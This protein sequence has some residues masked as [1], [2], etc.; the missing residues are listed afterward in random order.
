MIT[1]H[2]I[3]IQSGCSFIAK[4]GTIDIALDGTQGNLTVRDAG[5]FDAKYATL[6]IR[7]DI[8]VD[9]SATFINDEGKT[10]L[11]D[12]VSSKGDGVQSITGSLTFNELI[13]TT[14]TGI[15]FQ[16]GSTQTIL[17]KIYVRGTLGEYIH[18][19]SSEND[20]DLDTNDQWIL[21]LPL[22]STPGYTE[23][24]RYISV[25][26]SNNLRYDPNDDLGTRIEAHYA[27]DEGVNRGWFCDPHI[28]N[29]TG[30]TDSAWDVASNW[31]E[32]RTPQVMTIDGED[33]LDSVIIHNASNQPVLTADAH[34]DGRVLG[35]TID[36]GAT[37]DLG[38]YSF[39]VEGP[40]NNSGTIRLT[41]VSSQTI[42]F[43]QGNDI[44]SGTFRY[45]GSGVGEALTIKDFG[46]VDYYNLVV[47][48]QEDDVFSLEGASNVVKGNLSVTIPGALGEFQATGPTI[49][50]GN[51]TINDGTYTASSSTSVPGVWVNGILTG[52]NMTISGGASYA[53]TGSTVL[54]G[55]LT[56]NS[57]AYS[58]AQTTIKGDLSLSSGTYTASGATT[59]GYYAYNELFGGN[60]AMTNSSTYTSGGTTTINGSFIL[61]SGIYDSA[62]FATTVVRTMRI[63]GGEY[64]A[65]NVSDVTHTF[66]NLDVSGGTF[67]GRKATIDIN[68]DL[69]LGAGDFYMPEGDIW[70][71]G[72]WTTNSVGD[73]FQIPGA[74]NTVYFDTTNT[75]LVDGAILNKVAFYDLVIQDGGTL[76]LLNPLQ[77]TNKLE[78]KGGSTLDLGFFNLT[79]GE[80]DENG[81][82][83]PGTEGTFIN[84]KSLLILEGNEVLA[85]FTNDAANEG[86]VLYNSTDEVEFSDLAAGLH[87]YNLQ[88]DSAATFNLTGTLDVDGS[89]DIMNGTLKTNN[90][91]IEL[92]GNWN[93]DGTVEIGES[94][95]YLDGASDLYPQYITSGGTGAGKQFYN[96]EH[97]V[98]ADA[99]LDGT[100]KIDDPIMVLNNFTN[101]AGT[102]DVNDEDM[103]VIGATVIEGGEL[104]TGEGTL[105]L[106]TVVV[107]ESGEVI[108]ESL[109]PNDKI[110]KTSWEN[111]A[112]TVTYAATSTVDSKALLSDVYTY[113]TLAIDSVDLS[114]YTL[115]GNLTISGDLRL[116]G[117]KLDA[118]E[119]PLTG[120]NVYNI[121]LAGDWVSTGGVFVPRTSTVTL[122]G[123]GQ[124]ILGDN[125]FYNLVKDRSLATAPDTLTLESGKTLTIADEG[126]LTLKGG[127]NLADRLA[128]VSTDEGIQWKINIVGI[129]TSAVPTY[130]LEHLTVKDAHNVSNTPT[131]DPD[132]L[133]LYRRKDIIQTYDPTDCLD[134]GNNTRWLFEPA[135]P[136]TWLGDGL[137]E[138]NLWNVDA[139]WWGTEISQ[140]VWEYYV[141]GA[142]NKAIYDAHVSIDP[143]NI[144]A[145]VDVA[146]MDIR[147]RYS[148]VITQ[149]AGFAINVGALNYDQETG[150]KVV[151]N[152]SPIT[153]TGG[154][155]I[156]SGEIEAASGNIEIIAS[157]IKT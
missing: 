135:D 70:I 2:S 152:G 52:G 18:L 26:D 120:T 101:S 62:G 28:L 80:V 91:D 69:W 109:D 67:R 41:G 54:G 104:M 97:I 154:R 88:F 51:F 131:S 78:I 38:S 5:V 87:Y 82:L 7:G 93:N 65:S 40:V 58:G 27:N 156:N 103:V 151:T 76:V 25:K 1:T 157:D 77:V 20:A 3:N 147:T 60:M 98:N 145:V 116:K 128:L 21:D 63:E 108:I 59:I 138:G 30:A 111:Q 44:N 123:T 55:D 11:S 95:L 121:D 50:Y 10:I 6:T 33:L 73:L 139:N 110:I 37:L 48:A 134:Y 17:T 115:P 57:G 146:G 141:P 119:D 114:N 86:T 89:L 64:K 13:K 137:A 61:T 29:W 14:G 81:D 12:F 43:L 153:V 144:N 49:V 100:V 19:R 66:G 84:N 68:G 36:A 39:K 122:T 4:H 150:T 22:P 125:T 136:Y 140:G 113:D 9:D 34:D 112:G 35:L 45:T 83:I 32:G 85:G 42:T 94:T 46:G 53:S 75:H 118:L 126:K 124:S 74:T 47:A 106:D 90:H 15:I 72:D 148:G 127:A 16:A 130:E 71:A 149:N 105:T 31:E 8:D 96:I 79:L 99:Q 92:A 107:K 132:L 129:A 56:V 143:C 142:S 102:F 117:G 155:F 133:P 24:F 23:H